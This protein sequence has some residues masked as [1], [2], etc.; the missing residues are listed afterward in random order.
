[1]IN[2]LIC[3]KEFKA[4]TNTHLQNRHG[5]SIDDYLNKF[6][7]AEICSTETKEKVSKVMRKIFSENPEINIKKGINLRNNKTWQQ[8]HKNQLKNLNENPIVRKKR[9]ENSKNMWKD[10][11]KRKKL[12]EK[13][14]ESQNRPEVKK[15]KSEKLKGKNKT[16]RLNE[17]K[18][19]GQWAQ[20]SKKGCEFFDKLNKTFPNLQI[21]HALNG[22]EKKIVIKARRYFYL[23]GYSK[24]YNIA[25]EIDERKHYDCYNNLKQK[26]IDRQKYITQKIKCR[27]FRIKKEDINKFDFKIFGLFLNN[28]KNQELLNV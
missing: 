2:C 13:I 5:L 3:K 7:N 20:F 18:L 1:M 23:D 24:N 27:F 9:S 16:R 22:K 14:T 15:L 12:C 10:F 6:P 25:F 19:T 21:Q 28:I 26:D 4:V 17:T 8:N 11:K